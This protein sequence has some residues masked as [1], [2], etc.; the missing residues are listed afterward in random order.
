MKNID[1]LIV[2]ATKEGPT[3]FTLCDDCE[4]A[5][6]DESWDNA[7]YTG[8]DYLCKPCADKRRDGEPY[9][10]VMRKRVQP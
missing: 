4:D 10:P 8:P 6:A 2:E 9:S 3:G 7:P 1:R 5:L